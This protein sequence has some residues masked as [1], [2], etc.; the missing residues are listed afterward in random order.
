MAVEEKGERREL[1]VAVPTGRNL[2]K[3]RKDIGN[4]I[5][6]IIIIIKGKIKK[7]RKRRKRERNKREIKEI[8]IEIEI[9][10][11]EET[12]KEREKAYF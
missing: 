4:Y 3:K 9:E 6:I 5:Y 8:V 11:I 1:A 2:R 10:L 7:K 12:R